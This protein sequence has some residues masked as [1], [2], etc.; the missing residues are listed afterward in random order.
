MTST[1]VCVNMPRVLI[2]A[3]GN[4]LRSD[5][6]IASRAA[7]AI[8]GRFPESEVEILRLHQLAPE[9][10]DAIQ[11]RELVLFVDAACIESAKDSRAGEISVREVFGNGT[12]EPLPG[13][14]THA[15]SPAKVLDL[16]RELYGATPK[17]CVITAAGENFEHGE[18][19]S[20]PVAKALPDLTARV[21]QMVEDALSKPRTTKDTK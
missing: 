13:H 21:E 6:G 15:Y 5:D 9:V 4:P 2:V 12:G 17:A 14:F 19:L 20:I 11:N 8:Q 3:Y 1:L 18:C 7:D 10:A 16:G